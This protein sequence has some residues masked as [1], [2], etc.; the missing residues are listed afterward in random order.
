MVGG[1]GCSRVLPAYA[2]PPDGTSSN[3]KGTALIPKGECFRLKLSQCPARIW[4]PPA[5]GADVEF[6]ILERE[7]D[8]PYLI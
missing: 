6:G 1:N 4:A 5:I 8:L 7:L 2:M 3:G